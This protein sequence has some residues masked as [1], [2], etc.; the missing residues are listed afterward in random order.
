MASDLQSPP[1]SSRGGPADDDLIDRIK[2]WFLR[3]GVPQ[4]IDGYWL[5]E[6]M[7]VLFYLL[8]IV[9][10]FDL[11]IQPWVRF[12]PWFL[13]LAPVALAILGLSVGLFVKKTIIDQVPYLID[14]LTKE[15]VVNGK[16]AYPRLNEQLAFL[17]SNWIRVAA[18]SAGVFLVGSFMF[19]LGRDL[20]WTDFSVDFAVIAVLLWSSSTLFRPEVRSQVDAS[21][22]ERRRLYGVVA[23]AVVAFALEGSVLPDA[24]T[25]MNG[26]VGGVMPAAVPV[27]QAF[28]ALLVTIIIV[29]QTQGLVPAPGKLREVAAPQRFSAFFPALPLLVLLFCAETAILPYVGPEWLAAAVPLAAMVGLASLHRLVRRREDTPAPTDTTRRPRWL[30]MPTWLE[31][32]ANYPNVRRFFE[33]P[34]LTALVVLYLVACPLLVGALAAADE[35]QPSVGIA[36]DPVNAGSALLLAAAVNLF[37]LSVVVGIAVF[38]LHKI[39]RWAFEEAWIDWRGRISN[40]GRGLS[41]L[42]V[43]TALALLT[44]ETWETMR[45]I[46]TKDY[47]VLVGSI[48]GLTGAF[49]L[50]ISI[51]QV[52]ENAKFT[53]WS[54]IRTAALPEHASPGND[55]DREIRDL[56]ESDELRGLADTA[57][58]PRYP[59]GGLETVNSVIVMMI[60]EIFFFIPVTIIAAIVFLTLGH[61]AVPPEIAANWI[62]G[63]RATDAELAE[64]KGLPLIQQPWLR[65]GLLLTAFSILYLAVEVLSNPDQRSGFFTSAEKAVRRRLAVRLAYCELLQRR[66][67]LQPGPRRPFWHARY[68]GTPR[69]R[70]AARDLHHTRT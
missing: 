22:R 66:R 29:V 21:P 7:P 36:T 70:V 43:L 59:L 40:L 39:A 9:V 27:P 47:L 8:L 6:S 63:D 3:H 11:A 2:R 20:G 19:L 14:G 56:L 46:S 45:R 53:T 1:A 60:Y 17:I 16:P 48:L 32:V 24:T 15:K 64:L 18:L 12:N 68:R 54:Q 62:Y 26:V 4:F 57:D 50:L 52:T 67:L 42:V 58:A 30:R 44:A 35:N 69:R 28:A 55:R 34:G 49:H 41:I 65:V 31:R 25:M 23:A 51:Q 61:I 10:A 5:A 37:Y 13:L 38:K 33:Y